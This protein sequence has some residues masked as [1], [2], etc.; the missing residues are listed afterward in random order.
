[1]TIVSVT[2]R[3]CSSSLK[4]GKLAMYKKDKFLI[5]FLSEKKGKKTT[6]IKEI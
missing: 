5:T 3:D 2:L 4:K 1:M 6:K